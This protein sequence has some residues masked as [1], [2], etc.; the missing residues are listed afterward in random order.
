LATTIKIRAHISPARIQ[1]ARHFN[2][3]NI[4]GKKPGDADQTA[5]NRGKAPLDDKKSLPV[6]ELQADLV[7]CEVNK[8]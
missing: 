6:R 3:G 8:I 7:I 2:P 5:E 1:T 4:A